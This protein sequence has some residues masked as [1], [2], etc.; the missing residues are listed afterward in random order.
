MPKPIRVL[1]AKVGLDGH[2]LGILMVARR[3]QEAGMEV[4]YTGL[5]QSPEQVAEAAIQE[6]VD[7][8]GISS[9]SDSHME[10]APLVVSILR[11]KGA[12]IPVVLGGF[13]QPEDVPQ[14]KKEG[15]AEVFPINTTLE[16]AVAGIKKI[17]RR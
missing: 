15:V 8:V 9:L 11:G 4:I 5:H 3:L 6:N 16:S 12:E 13:I 10:L 2:D 14:L 1:L 7:V 17:A